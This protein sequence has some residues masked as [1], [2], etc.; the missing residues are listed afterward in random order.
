VRTLK[1][2]LDLD[3]HFTLDAEDSELW[4][5]FAAATRDFG[6]RFFTGEALVNHMNTEALII[7]LLHYTPSL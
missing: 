4:T 7:L 6:G 2:Y 1:I 3:D 5:L